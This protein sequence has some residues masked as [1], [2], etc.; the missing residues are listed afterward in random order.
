M[1]LFAWAGQFGSACLR[2]NIPS[3]FQ[4]AVVCCLMNEHRAAAELA[5]L[6][7]WEGPIYRLSI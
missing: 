5:G 2:S 4:N 6:A 1:H 3:D 7:R